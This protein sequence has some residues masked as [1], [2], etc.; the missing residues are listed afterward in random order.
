MESAIIAVVREMILHGLRQHPPGDAASPEMLAG[1]ASWAIY[2]GA[3][4]WVQ[5][6]D[7]VPSD[8]AADTVMRLAAPDPPAHA[9][10]GRRA[11][12][13]GVAWARGTSK[14]LSS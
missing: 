5:T 2:G 10:M 8:E 13:N 6:P 3:K 11:F 12:V 7:R 9:G 14:T 4:E 1:M